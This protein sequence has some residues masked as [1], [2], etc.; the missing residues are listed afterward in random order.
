MPIHIILTIASDDK[1]GL[2]QQLSTAV[3]RNGGNWL[4]S[5]LAHLGGKFV[6]VIQISVDEAMEE[7]LTIALAEL[8]SQGIIVSSERA[9]APKNASTEEASFSAIGPD[10]SGIIKELSAAFARYQ[11][12]VEELDSKLS[13]MPYSGEPIFEANGRISLPSNFDL[14]DLH[15]KLHAIANDLGIDIDLERKG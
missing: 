6:G 2:I 5:K 11:I 12:N 1:P 8:A 14:R 10:R 7:A 15:D 4:E 9:A 3:E 13:S